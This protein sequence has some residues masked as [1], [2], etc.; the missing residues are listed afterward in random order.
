MTGQAFSSSHDAEI[1]LGR[2][3]SNDITVP[4]VALSRL[5]CAFTSEPDGWHVRDVGAV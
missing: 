3:S 5:H 4:D 2:D 1:T